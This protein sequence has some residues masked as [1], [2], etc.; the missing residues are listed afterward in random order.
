MF[1]KQLYHYNKYWLAVF[2]CFILFF[3]YINYK[4]GVVATPVYQYGM[5]SG[6]Y[7]VK[8]TLTIYKFYIDEK[9]LNPATIHFTQKDMLFTMTERFELAIKNPMVIYKTLQGVFDKIGLG[10]IVAEDKYRQTTTPTDFAKWLLKYS[11][12]KGS[13]L[14]V[15]RQQYLWVKNSLQPVSSQQTMVIETN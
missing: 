4:W 1:I 10:K 6:K 3:L 14:K 8:D 11:K 7:Y 2:L 15:M 13:S 12:Q 9:E 5:F